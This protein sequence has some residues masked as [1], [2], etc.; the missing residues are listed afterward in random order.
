MTMGWRRLTRVVCGRAVPASSA[1]VR[2]ESPST[3]PCARNAVPG[4]ESVAAK[5]R[6]RRSRVRR[7]SLASWVRCTLPS[8][9]MSTTIRSCTRRPSGVV[10]TVLEA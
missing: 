3:S 10:S 5:P 6:S 2:T 7:I 4:A 1:T 9:S 8:A